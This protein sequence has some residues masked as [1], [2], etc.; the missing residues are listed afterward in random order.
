MRVSL[1]LLFPR[2]FCVDF[3]PSQNVFLVS[4]V[5]LMGAYRRHRFGKCGNFQLQGVQF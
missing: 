3:A 1:I 4:A 2:P 5:T